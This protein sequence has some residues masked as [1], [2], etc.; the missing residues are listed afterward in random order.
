MSTQNLSEILE[1]HP[2]FKDLPK[3]DRQLLAGCGQNVVVS[4]STFLAHEGDAADRFFV[5]RSGLVAVEI[6]GPSGPQVLQTLG[7][8]EVL[9]WSW[10]FPPYKWTFDVRVVETLHAV[11]L[12]GKCLRGKCEADPAMG[13]RLMKRFA[14]MMTARLRL[15]RL[16]LLDVYKAPGSK[17]L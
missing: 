2:F 5:I 8:G 9:G 6:H 17:P 11:A 15:T 1:A 10:L 3:G 16:Q 12:D 13:Y 7:A 14:E 4:R